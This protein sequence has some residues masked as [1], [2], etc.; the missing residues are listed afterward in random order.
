MKWNEKVKSML[1]IFVIFA[2]KLIFHP[3]DTS[4]STRVPVNYL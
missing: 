4:D 1:Q 3:H 2:E